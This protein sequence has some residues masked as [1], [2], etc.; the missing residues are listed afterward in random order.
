MAEKNPN[1]RGELVKNT[2]IDNLVKR[3][4]VQFNPLYHTGMNNKEEWSYKLLRRLGILPSHTDDQ[5]EQDK[6]EI[7]PIDERDKLFK[8]MHIFLTKEDLE[9]FNLT[10]RKMQETAL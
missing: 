6:I 9:N 3:D 1:I 4:A 8:K 10:L 7:M 2:V 5:G